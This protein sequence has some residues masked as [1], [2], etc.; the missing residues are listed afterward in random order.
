MI[1]VVRF[2]AARQSAA[3]KIGK[4]LAAAGKIGRQRGPPRTPAE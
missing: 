4:Y 1:Y 2:G 3:Q